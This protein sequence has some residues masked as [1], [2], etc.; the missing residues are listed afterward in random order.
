MR[1]W[2]WRSPLP[3]WLLRSVDVRSENRRIGRRPVWI[4]DERDLMGHAC[5]RNWENVGTLQD[6]PEDG[7]KM[8]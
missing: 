2:D 8:A 1:D 6:V 3:R 5:K 4:V 7:M